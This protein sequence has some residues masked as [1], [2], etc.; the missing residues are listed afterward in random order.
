MKIIESTVI[1]RN[2]S[3]QPVDINGQLSMLNMETGKYVVLNTVGARIW[4]LA[5]QPIAVRDIIA[6]L[7]NEFD[8]TYEDCQ[9]SVLLYMKNL[10]KERLIQIV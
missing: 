1:K 4:E 3:L 6:R 7:I 9:N 2:T 5:E 10:K 8:V